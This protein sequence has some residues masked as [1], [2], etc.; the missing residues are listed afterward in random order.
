LS[1]STSLPITYYLKIV[2]GFLNLN[3]PAGWTSHDCVAKVR[4]ILRTKKVGHGGTLD[5][6][7]TGVLPIA[8]GKATRLLP[9]LPEGK[10]YRAVIRFGIQTTTDDLAGEVLYSQAV[11]QLAIDDVR[12][13]LPQFI[14]K[15]QQIPP[16]YS[17]I[18][19]NGQRM[20]KLARSGEIVD[21]PARE[22]TIDDI[23]IVNWLPGDF[24]ELEVDITCGGGTYIRSIARDLG[25]VLNTKA[26][27]AKLIRTASCGAILSDSISLEDLQ[28]QQLA[29][30]FRPISLLQGL[31]HL[32]RIVLTDELVIRWHRGQRLLLEQAPI[33]VDIC[34]AIDRSDRVL[35]IG[36]LK[37]TDTGYLL[38]PQIVF[39]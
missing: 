18:Q 38:S 32:S 27:L 4:G 31:P 35:G 7:A 12:S 39:N 25:E 36:R 23:V 5:P 1:F 26:T 8:I 10:A 20:Y 2:D 34:I 3:K 9:Y 19:I 21:I 33:G 37:S 22:V 24:P 29:G 28:Q 30:T 14:G 13:I 6:A 11:P 16:M 17:A 15:I